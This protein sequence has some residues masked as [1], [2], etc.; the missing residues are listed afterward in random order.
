MIPGKIRLLMFMSAMWAI[1]CAGFTYDVIQGEKEALY[2]QY[3]TVAGNAEN[4]PIRTE[5]ITAEGKDLTEASGWAYRKEVR[6]LY[7]IFAPF[8]WL[9]LTL[10]G[11]IV[12]AGVILPIHFR[13]TRSQ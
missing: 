4:E 11:C 1:V 12:A 5:S 10:S 2:R 8:L 6:E 13:S 7:W 3:F 9:S